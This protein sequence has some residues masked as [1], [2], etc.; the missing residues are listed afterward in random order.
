MTK[1]FS[2]KNFKIVKKINKEKSK[3]NAKK[4]YFFYLLLKNLCI[5]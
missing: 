2:I 5:K 1:N 4:I 3:K